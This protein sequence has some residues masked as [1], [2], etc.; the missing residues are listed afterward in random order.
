VIPRAYTCHGAGKSPPISWSGIPPRTK[1]VALVVDD[2]QAP[3]TPYVYW[4]VFDISPDRDSIE[5]G[6]P[7]PGARVARNS[8]GTARYDPPC[9]HGG[10][11]YYRFTVYALNSQLRLRSGSGLAATWSAIAADVIGE[12]R[13]TVTAGP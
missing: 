3:I 13:L 8:A 4:I 1:S 9:P 5:A 12:G 6:V 10:D 11:H 2:A 7:P